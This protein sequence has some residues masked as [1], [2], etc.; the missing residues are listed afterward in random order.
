MVS[1]APLPVVETPVSG[2]SIA[3]LP[4]PPSQPVGKPACAKSACS[5]WPGPEPVGRSFIAR[6][7][8]AAS[9]LVGTASEAVDQTVAIGAV[10]R[11]AGRR[12]YAWPFWLMGRTWDVMS[13]SVLLAVVAAAPILQ[14]ASLGYILFAAGRLANGA[15]W[16]SAFPG[17]RTAG[18]LGTFAMLAAISW[19]P[20]I[21]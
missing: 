20:S 14:F 7:G 8:Q 18:K 9:T 1:A 12:W 2:A 4:N 6:S 16:R 13:L 21:F 17:L 11:R 5:D 15:R 10:K 3:G 19:I